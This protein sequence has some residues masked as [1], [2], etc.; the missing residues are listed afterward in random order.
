M[1]D[2]ETFRWTWEGFATFNKSFDRHNLEAVAGL[3][4]EKYGVGVTST[5]TGY[6]VPRSSQYWNLSMVSG[7]YETEVAQFGYTPTAIASY[8]GRFQ[9]NYDHK[10]Y[11]SAVLR[12]DGASTFKQNEDYWGTFPSIGL[13]WTLTQEEFMRDV[14]FL[15]HLKLKGT[16]GMLGNHNVPEYFPSDYRPGQCHHE[17][18]VWSGPKLVYGATFGTPAMDLSWEVTREWGGD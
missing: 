15:D 14:D 3:S 18:R 6:E 16:W 10:Y 12:R 8:F 9:Y 2:S 5:L 1:N 7:D 13:G 4:R 11:L 17:L